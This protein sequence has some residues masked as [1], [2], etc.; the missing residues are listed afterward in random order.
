MKYNVLK[1]YLNKCKRENKKP[2]FLELKTYD[3]QIKNKL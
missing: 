1:S 3:K 2:N